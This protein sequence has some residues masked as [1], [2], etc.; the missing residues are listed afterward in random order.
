MAE[1]RPHQLGE[2]QP[3][4]ERGIGPVG[5]QPRRDLRQKRQVI[6]GLRRLFQGNPHQR[7]EIGRKWMW[8]QRIA[9]DHAGI[10]EGRLLARA[11][12]VEQGDAQPAL[13]EMQRNGRADDAGA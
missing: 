10:A 8:K 5:Q 13:G 1:Q 7:T 12:A 9:F 3:P 4:L 2:L 11:A 6:V